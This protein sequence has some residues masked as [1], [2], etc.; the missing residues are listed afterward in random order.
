MVPV[1][2]PPHSFVVAAMATFE[3]SGAKFGNWKENFF[4]SLAIGATAPSLRLDTS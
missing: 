2:R 1:K 3:L 4:V